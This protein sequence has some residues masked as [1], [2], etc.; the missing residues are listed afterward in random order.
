MKKLFQENYASLLWMIAAGFTMPMFVCTSCLHSTP[1]YIKV[2]LLNAVMWVALWLGNHYVGCWIDTKI[3]WIERPATRFVVGM[4]SATLYTIGIIYI[5]LQV[6]EWTVNLRLPDEALRETFV[7]ALAIT[8]AIS[9]FM[10][11]RAFLL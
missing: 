5:I 6:F 4:I 3:S 11:S 2:G 1:L 10:H 7:I 8:F 9:F